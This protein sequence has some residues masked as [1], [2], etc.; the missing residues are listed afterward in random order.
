GGVSGAKSSRPQL[1]QLRAGVMAG[2]VEVIVANT[3]D[4]FTRDEEQWFEF[5]KNVPVRIITL[6]GVDT[7]KD[8]R[9][10]SGM[11]VL[12][13]ADER[14]KIYGRT[15][16]GRLARVEDGHWVGGDPPFGHK[17]IDAYE[18]ENRRKVP[19]KLD[20]DEVEAAI[21]RRAVELI[22]DE[23]HSTAKAAEILNAEGLFRRPS[24]LQRDGVP[25]RWDSYELRKMLRS[26]SLMGRYTWAKKKSA[27]HEPITVQIPPVLEAGRWLDLQQVLKKTERRPYVQTNVYPLSG[28]VISACG[29][30]YV[31]FTTHPERGRLMRCTGKKRPPRCGCHQIR[32]SEIEWRVWQ[33]VYELI[34]DE[35]RL[36]ALAPGGEEAARD[37]GAA[38]KELTRLD[39]LIAQK[40]HAITDRA[41]EAL[42]AGLSPD[43]IA[44]AVMQIEGDLEVLREQRAEMCAWHSETAESETRKQRLRYF[45]KLA[46]VLMNPPLEVMHEVFR[47]LDIEVILSD[48][49]E[50]KVTVRGNVTSEAIEQI[51]RRARDLSGS[52]STRDR[53]RARGRGAA[54]TP[55]ARAARGVRRPARRACA[56]RSGAAARRRR[57]SRSG[58][59]AAAPRGCVRRA[60][61]TRTAAR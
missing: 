58:A 56:C 48:D 34:T 49:D 29:E 23:L 10:L 28:R 16:S 25:R 41:A 8:D 40:E 26:E 32:A 45:V 36:V 55:S 3:L 30:R 53:V 61:G 38:S 59:R 1:D 50:P 2:E 39:A 9:L 42:V 4:R 7:G 19:R 17:V 5:T 57:P 15:M 31:G 51:G 54:R 33:A 60:P 22:V 11:R 27:K 12:I 13:A 18:A 37:A 21:A 20:V 46:Q 52:S 43:V 44:K 35:E 14:R 24:R 6:D 47:L